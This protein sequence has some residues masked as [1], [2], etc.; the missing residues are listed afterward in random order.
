MDFDTKFVFQHLL[1]I[2]NKLTGY[3]DLLER[4]VCIF[5]INDYIYTGK[6]LYYKAPL[7]NKKAIQIHEEYMGLRYPDP[8]KI[9]AP[10]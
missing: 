10:D 3:P 5:K 6:P 1:T 9:R 7:K 4:N 8:S 2:E